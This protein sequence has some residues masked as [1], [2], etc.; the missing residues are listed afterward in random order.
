M[1]ALLLV[2]HLLFH[3]DLHA[4][5]ELF[6]CGKRDAVIPSADKVVDG[7]LCNAADDTQPVDG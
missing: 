5:A 7:R 2:W 3:S 4:V 6:E 1:E